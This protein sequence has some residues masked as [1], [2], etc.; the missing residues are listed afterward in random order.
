MNVDL[1]Q[2]IGYKVVDDKKVPP[3]KPRTVVK[4]AGEEF[5]VGELKGTGGFAKVFSATFNNKDGDFEDVVLKVQKPAND[6][7]WYLLN[8]VHARLNV[9]DHP[10][11]RAGAEWSRSFMS[12]SRCI[13]YQLGSI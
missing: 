1:L 6:W 5:L 7:E 12:A 9:L 8:E 11:L 3:V 10:D 2:T 13:T 4:L